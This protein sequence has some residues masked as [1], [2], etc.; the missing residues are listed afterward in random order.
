MENT[1][2]VTAESCDQGARRPSMPSIRPFGWMHSP[3]ARHAAQGDEASGTV[4]RLQSLGDRVVSIMVVEDDAA[5]R[6]LY[7][8]TLE[9]TSQPY[10]ITEFAYAEEALEAIPQVQPECILLD[11]NLPDLDGMAFLRR[12]DGSEE[13]H[14]AERPSVVM[15]TAFEERGLG[16]QA[17]KAGA[18]DFLSKQLLDATNLEVAVHRALREFD[19]RKLRARVRRVE[20]MAALGHLAAGVAHEVN[21]PATFVT[22]NLHLI[23]RLL[24]SARTKD[25]IQLNAEDA[26]ELEEMLADSVV[27]IQRISAI[28]AELR[29]QTRPRLEHIERTSLDAVVQAAYRLLK[30]RDADKLQVQF[31]LGSNTPVNLDHG[32]MVQVVS[33]LVVNALQASGDQGRVVVRTF[34]SGNSVYLGVADSGPGVPRALRRRIFE[35]FY[36]TKDD[37]RGMGLGLALCADYVEKHGGTISVEDAQLGGAEFTVRLPINNGLVVSGQPIRLLEPVASRNPVRAKVLAIDD[38]PAILR[39]YQRILEP[40]FDVSVCANPEEALELLL[41]QTFDVVLCD[42]VMPEVDGIALFDRARSRMQSALPRFVFCTGGVIDT[43]LSS[44]LKERAVETLEKP[45]SPARLLD[46]LAHAR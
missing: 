34:E 27:G 46:L 25:G 4:R 9:A 44:R 6:K 22:A 7:R 3:A 43:E 20:K 18:S 42:V 17:L 12:L 13:N 41:T 16:V 37:K 26:A 10:L 39:A 21:N 32:K 2:L 11:F 15:L 30:P 45:L 36:T 33:N 29:S 24:E 1:T 28:V 38:E 23:Q 19:S 31:D 5:D 35:P 40:D 8:R 14:A